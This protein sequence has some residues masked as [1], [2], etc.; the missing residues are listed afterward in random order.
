M[1][2]SIKKV[3]SLSLLTA[4]LFA[5]CNANAGFEDDSSKFSAAGLSRSLHN[6]QISSTVRIYS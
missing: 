2:K 4:V 3:F 6:G 5:G 1:L